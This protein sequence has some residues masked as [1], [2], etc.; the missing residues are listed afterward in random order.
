M[1][2]LEQPDKHAFDLYWLAFLLTGQRPASVDLTVEAL[3]S[4]DDENP[5]FSSWMLDWSRR[6]VIAKALAVVR[7]QLAESARRTVS[8]RL[9]RT[10][11]PARNWSLDRDTTKLQIESALMAIDAFPKCALLLSI[12]EGVPL[13]DVATLLESDV[14]LVRKARAIGL[15]ELTRN[16]ARMQSW[17]TV[18]ARSFGIPG[19]VQHA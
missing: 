15:Q 7:R 1:Q 3:R 14:D 9:D 5:F 6:V 2:T 8:K 19:E 18:A 12:F 13:Q 4:G 17:K 10:A 16:L 11:L